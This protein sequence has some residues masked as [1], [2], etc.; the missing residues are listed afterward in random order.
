[1]TEYIFPVKIAHE[2]IAEGIF[3]GEETATDSA[4]IK[5][6]TKGSVSEVEKRKIAGA[7][8]KNDGKTEDAGLESDKKFSA[9]STLL[10][11]KTL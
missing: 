5:E 7:D 1:M 10:R 3:A 4:F 2:K 6:I 9:L 8:L 11:K